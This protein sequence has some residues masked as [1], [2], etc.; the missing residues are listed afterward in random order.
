MAAT[1]RI[2]AAEQILAWYSRMAPMRTPNL[3]MLP[4]ANASLR[5]KQNLDRFNRFC[6]VHWYVQQTDTQAHRARYITTSCCAWP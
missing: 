1:A 6:T 2:A 5:P 4:W 3:I